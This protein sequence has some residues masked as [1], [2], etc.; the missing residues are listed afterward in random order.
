MRRGTRPV[1][2]FCSPSGSRFGLD[3]VFG[4]AAAFR[5]GRDG[6]GARVEC[7]GATAGAGTLLGSGGAALGAG[8]LSIGVDPAGSARGT[9]PSAG[10]VAAVSPV[11]TAVAE[12]AS[13]VTTS[14]TTA[15]PPAPGATGPQRR[16]RAS[17]AAYSL[18]AALGAQCRRKMEMSAAES[19]SG[20][21]ELEHEAL[22]F[23]VAAGRSE[24]VRGSDRVDALER[25]IDGAQSAG[26]PQRRVT[27]VCRRAV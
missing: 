12:P 22:H 17:S 24:T 21:A 4:G 25:H 1:T 8:E 15:T 16:R 2:Y 27:V 13:A 7:E 18:A 5:R 3:G 9:V 20:L 14:G 23:P 10:A 6:G 26:R 11:S 19:E